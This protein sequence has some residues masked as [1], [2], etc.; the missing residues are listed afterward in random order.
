[1]LAVPSER[2]R[3]RS[4]ESPVPE[5]GEDRVLPLHRGLEGSRIEHVALH[6]PQLWML[7]RKPGRVAHERSHLV[8]LRER[9]LDQLSAGPAGRADHEEAQWSVFA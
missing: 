2:I 4:E 7:E 5:R 6:D 3:R 8:A 1:M 9:L